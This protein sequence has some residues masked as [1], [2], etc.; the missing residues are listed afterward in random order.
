MDAT[1]V[2]AGVMPM[3]LEMRRR[4][5]QGRMKREG[6]VVLVNEGIEISG[7]NWRGSPQGQPAS[8]WLYGRLL[9][10]ERRSGGDVY[11]VSTRGIKMEKESN[12]QNKNG[13]DADGREEE[14]IE[15]EV[16]ISEIEVEEG[17]RRSRTS[18]SEMDE[19]V[20]VS[21][22]AK[23]S[24]QKRKKRIRSNSEGSPEELRKRYWPGWESVEL[25]RRLENMK[26]KVEEQI[27]E[28]RT[29][30]IQN[31]SREKHEKF[32]SMRFKRITD[33][34]ETFSMDAKMVIAAM[35][36]ERRRR[37]SVEIPKEAAA[38]GTLP[39]RNR[40]ALLSASAET[41]SEATA[42]ADASPKTATRRPPAIQ[43]H[44][45]TNVRAFALD[46]EKALKTK[47][48]VVH[49][50]GAIVARTG[51]AA[52]TRGDTCRISLQTTENF[53]DAKAFFA[54]NSI[55]YSTWAEK[56]DR[57]T[58]YVISGLSSGTTEEEIFEDLD[59]VGIPVRKVRQLRM[60]DGEK[61]A[62]FSFAAPSTPEWPQGRILNMKS[63]AHCRISVRKYHHDAPQICHRCSRFGHSSTH[64]HAVPRNDRLPHHPPTSPRFAFSIPGYAIFRSDRAAAPDGEER[65]GGGTAIAI[66]DSFVYSLPSPHPEPQHDLEATVV[67]LK[68]DFGDISVISG[69]PP[70]RIHFV[71]GAFGTTFSKGLR[72][73]IGGD[74]NAKHMTW[75]S[76]CC[77]KSGRMLRKWVDENAVQ[78]IGPR[79]PTRFSPKGSGDVLDIFLLSSFL[80]PKAIF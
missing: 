68:T 43:V 77:N 15:E 25:R 53:R 41:A 27:G 7:R 32:Y 29:Y 76:N 8:W 48:F 38:S 20:F 18:E 24:T 56:K 35:E 59:A 58:T 63:L 45:I 36:R 51:D 21:E 31:F 61:V 40:Y 52:A 10:Y 37:E 79:E 54:T 65:K 75:G 50:L 30:L 71:N 60:K 42:P 33:A 11:I 12:K 67:R 1:N 39:T 14:H 55:A 72:A 26:K 4:W 80:Q 5:L 22:G 57:L 47:D 69:Y 70:P 17:Q 44:G 66:A 9:R 78:V 16:E 2:I 73:V 62:L 49:R 34:M 3:D 74:F 23:G 64:C 28:V 19:E 13:G 6:R 46:L